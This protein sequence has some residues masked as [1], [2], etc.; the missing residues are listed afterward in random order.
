M[1]SLHTKGGNCTSGN[2]ASVLYRHRQAGGP[3]TADK[4]LQSGF[5]SPAGVLETFYFRLGLLACP[6][7][8]LFN[9]AL[10][11]FLDAMHDDILIFASL[12]RYIPI[13]VLSALSLPVYIRSANRRALFYQCL[14]IL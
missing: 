13:L 8:E 3:C 4:D 2:F 12:V 1:D 9:L 7:R 14:K 5:P 10:K 11:S 6:L